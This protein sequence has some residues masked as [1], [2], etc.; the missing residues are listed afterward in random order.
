MIDAPQVARLETLAMV[1]RAYALPVDALLSIH[2]H[3]L[4]ALADVSAFDAAGA[5]TRRS[6]E[7]D[8]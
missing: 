1:A 3:A 4:H 6:S 8:Q 5:L 2:D 7:H